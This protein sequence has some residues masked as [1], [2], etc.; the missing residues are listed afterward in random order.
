MNASSN[1]RCN[2]VETLTRKNLFLPPLA[3]VGRTR[4]GESRGKGLGFQM[5]PSEP[6]KISVAAG[7]RLLQRSYC[8][9]T[10]PPFSGE[11]AAIQWGF[12]ITKLAKPSLSPP[13]G[14]DFPPPIFRRLPPNRGARA[15]ASITQQIQS[16]Y[17]LVQSSDKPYC[18]R[19]PRFRCVLSQCSA[20]CT[21]AATN[22][23]TLAFSSLSLVSCAWPRNERRR[24]TR[25]PLSRGHIGKTMASIVYRDKNVFLPTRSTLGQFF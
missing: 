12:S 25:P 19:S 6:P 20:C 9:K 16:L 17:Q 7:L 21:T 23:R 24:H 11:V 8:R 2:D 13:L 14:G 5:T 18:G 1:N 10:R 3:G 4:R 22:G 15:S